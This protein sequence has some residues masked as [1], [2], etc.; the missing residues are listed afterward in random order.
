MSSRSV[1]GLVYTLQG[2]E[3][4]GEDCSPV[5]EKYG[6]DPQRL[7]PTA[8]IE[9]SRELQILSELV[10]HLQDPLAGLKA[11]AHFSLA[12][13]GP[14]SMLLM[15]CKNAWQALHV[16][17]RYRELTYLF[18]EL[19]LE[20][21]EHTSAV[22]LTPPV[23]PAHILRFRVDGEVSGTFQLMRDMQANLGTDLLPE[24]I[25]IPYET[26]PE[27][28]AYREH[29]GCPVEFDTDRAR[30]HLRNEH[31][32]LPFPTANDTAHRMYRAQCDQLLARR[33]T[34]EAGLTERVRHYL[35]MFQDEYPPAAQVAATFGIAERSF[36]RQLNREGS[37]FRKLLNEVR[38]RK[39]Q[40][41]LENTSMPVEQIAE[42]LG[43]E[44]SAAFIHAFRRWAGT[45]PAR[46]RRQQ[47]A[48][49][50]PGRTMNAAKR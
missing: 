12:G 39:A 27:A 22:V 38:L 13:Y 6:L 10:E 3:A 46:W 33:E 24:R 36:R 47:C 48:E 35:E 49:E 15:T 20:P 11:G 2:L 7:D 19:S 14:F 9:R 21:G 31:L 32:Q 43:Y 42:R 50:E 40:Q 44:E 45:T 17:L 30:I 8:E 29:F 23:L 18:S 25:D 34:S 5:L 16:A 4:I 37:S 28:T 41:Y 1:L 26:P